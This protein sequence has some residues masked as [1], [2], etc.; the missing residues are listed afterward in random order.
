MDQ[1]IGED[2]QPESGE[3]SEMVLVEQDEDQG[4]DVIY[5]GME[6]GQPTLNIEDRDR[7]GPSEAQDGGRDEE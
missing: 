3:E 5:M 6:V 1:N 2:E 7:E 4:S